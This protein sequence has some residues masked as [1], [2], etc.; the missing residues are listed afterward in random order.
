MRRAIR[1]APRARTARTRARAPRSARRPASVSSTASAPAA[2][3][4]RL[5]HAVAADLADG[6]S[7]TI[8]AGVASARGAQVEL[9]DLTCRADHALYAAKAA[10]R[11]Q[12]S[13]DEDATAASRPVR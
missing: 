2:V 6:L 12:V 11:N 1:S 9:G 4:E 10:G 13:C 7:V 3:A 8:S 5:R